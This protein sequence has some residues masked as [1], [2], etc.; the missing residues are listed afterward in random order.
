MFVIFCSPS[1]YYVL[2]RWTPQWELKNPYHPWWPSIVR[3]SPPLWAV[4]NIYGRPPVPW[5]ANLITRVRRSEDCRSGAGGIPGETCAVFWSDVCREVDEKIRLEV[6]GER[7][8]QNLLLPKLRRPR[9]IF[10]KFSTFSS[11][12]TVV[13][14]S[15]TCSFHRQPPDNL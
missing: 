10:V 1:V 3:S 11:T 6:L 13:R 14:H 9:I 5:A 4:V 2:Q 7:D 15:V 12:C 8:T